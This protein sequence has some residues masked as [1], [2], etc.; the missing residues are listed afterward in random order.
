MGALAPI[1][2]WIPED[3]LLLKNS[4]EAGASLESLAKGAVRF[5]RRFTLHELQ[6]RWYSLLY[7]PVVSEHAS[8]RMAEILKCTSNLSSK[9][10]KVGVSKNSEGVSGK[11]KEESVCGLY[12]AMRK[13]VCTEPCSSIDLAYLVAPS[14]RKCTG[15]GEVCQDEFRQLK[16]QQ[17][18]RCVIG[19]PIT[20]V[21]ELQ[22]S[23]FDV[24]RHAFP[25]IAHGDN[26]EGNICQNTH[27]FHY[28]HMGSFEGDLRD[29][30]MDRDCLYGFSENVS[31]FSV[32]EAVGNNMGHSFDQHVHKDIPDVLGGSM[33]VFENNT[34]VQKI[35]CPGEL[36]VSAYDSITNN[37]Q[38][39]CSGFEGN[40]DFSSTDLDC[41]PSFH[42]LGFSSPTPG[43]PEITIRTMQIDDNLGDKDKSAGCQLALPPD[44]G[45][46]HVRTG[47]QLKERESGDLL[48][49][50]TSLLEG[51]LADLAD[52][53]FTHEDV[54]LF[55]DDDSKDML[56]KSCLDGISSVLFSSPNDTHR[57]VISD[58]SGVRASTD[59][60]G[61]TIANVARSLELDVVNDLVS[62]SQL[63]CDSKIDMSTTARAT[64]L[65]FPEYRN[66]VICCVL[67]TEDPDIPC[68]DN[69]FTPNQVLP[70]FVTSSMQLNHE[71]S[72][73]PQS[74]KDLPTENQKISEQGS[75]LV[76]EGQ[77]T[78]GIVSSQ[79]IEPQKIEPQKIEVEPQVFPEVS[80]SHSINGCTVISETVD[81]D[82]RRQGNSGGDPS[83]CRSLLPSQNSSA[84]VELNKEYKQV[85]LGKH[86][87]FENF[88]LEKQIHASDHL[89]NQPE[90]NIDDSKQE[91]NVPDTI[92]VHAESIPVE[93]EFQENML[94][95]SIPD[96]EQQFSE[97]DDD[98]PSFSDVEAMIL[99][100]DLDP[101][102]ED[103]HLSKEV[104]SYQYDDTKRSIIKLEQGANSYMQR[105][106]ASQKAFAIFYGRHLKYYIKKPEVLLGRGTG[107]VSVD[108]DLGREGRANKIS[109][110]QAII[111]ME[112]DGSFYLKNL[113]K[114]S[115][116]VNGTELPGGH[117]LKL[118]SSCLIEIRDMKFLFEVNHYLVTQYLAKT[119]R[120]THPVN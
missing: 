64:N 28:G 52:M 81:S 43:M 89:N 76:N 42:Q 66:G 77:Q 86:S 1:S 58:I 103:L 100:M 34:S 97:M 7:D 115:L 73:V 13:R 4:V 5:S 84:A 119:A 105:A 14:L 67:N 21:F 56:D 106:V 88:L 111:K 93:M 29:G 49:N 107:D 83:Q 95:P 91:N 108:I 120:K 55:M 37:P 35:R 80:P 116:M 110:R 31:P 92:E 9:S 69:D 114:C 45:N 48:A 75:H 16:E 44:G 79:K 112:K 99:D 40:Q 98:I 102:N 90:A 41:G 8:T 19:G 109:R 71:D 25:Q 32:T 15:N 60:E 59:L 101:V 65:N 50:S 24:V 94:N 117:R 62:S 104:A 12:Y 85:E 36:P 27:A 18:D 118:S 82:T 96:Q 26:V 33:S 63:V 30:M 113:G 3:D 61:F 39:V 11:R 87:E 53:N 70:S 54:L 47:C 20:E 23:D 22:D 38:N 74:T 78:S 57:N 72:S 2:P 68:N 6:E 17:D 46:N 10:E 51:D